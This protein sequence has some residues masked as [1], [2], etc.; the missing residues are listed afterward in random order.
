MVASSNLDEVLGTSAA[1]KAAAAVPVEHK[2]E[3]EDSKYHAGAW[4][5]P[6]KKPD[7]EM[8]PV[9]PST[10]RELKATASNDMTLPS[11]R[12]VSEEMQRKR[13]E[14]EDADRRKAT[15]EAER[16]RAEEEKKSLQGVEEAN[17]R[18]WKKKTMDME[19]RMTRAEKDLKFVASEHN[20]HSAQ[21]KTLRAQATY[22]LAKCIEEERADASKEAVF[23]GWWKWQFSSSTSAVDMTQHRREVVLWVLHDCNVDPNTVVEVTSM[24]GTSLQPITTVKF[25]TYE[26]KKGFMDKVHEKHDRKIKEWETGAS[27]AAGLTW[28]SGSWRPILVETAIGEHD[29]KLSYILKATME[30]FRKAAVAVKPKWRTNEVVTDDNAEESIAWVDLDLEMGTANVYYNEEQFYDEKT[31]KNFVGDIYDQMKEIVSGRGGGKGKKGKGKGKGKD[32]DREEAE[33]VIEKMN[34]EAYRHYMQEQ[35]KKHGLRFQYNALKAKPSYMVETTAL[36]AQ[37]YKNSWYN[38]MDEYG[39]R[40]AHPKVSKNSSWIEVGTDSDDDDL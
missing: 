16:R 28:S 5:E 7:E 15:E 12:T 35:A 13:K 37:D 3:P 8:I 10:K 40:A 4:P 23:K 33:E 29:R 19:T 2:E 25:T 9:T 39:D 6:P 31:R 11:K 22:V 36:N 18:P 14:A 34:I 17:R 24:K 20:K 30:A 21:L 38:C 1:A 27:K 26:A 32:K